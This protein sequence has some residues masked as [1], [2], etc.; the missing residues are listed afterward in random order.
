MKQSKFM[1]AR[2]ENQDLPQPLPSIAVFVNA[3]NH[4]ITV[5]TRLKELKLAEKVALD[6]AKR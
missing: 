2:W 4:T 3:A 6:G 5:E 1:K